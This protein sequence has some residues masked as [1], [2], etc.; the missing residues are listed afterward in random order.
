MGRFWKYRTNCPDVRPRGWLNLGPVPHWAPMHCDATRGQV[1]ALLVLALIVTLTGCGSAESSAGAGGPCLD[2]YERVIGDTGIAVTGESQSVDA[3]LGYATINYCPGNAEHGGLEADGFFYSLDSRAVDAQPGG[4][5]AL[6]A[7]G[8]PGARLT[9]A[10]PTEDP[11]T[12]APS[13][14]LTRADETTW[15]LTAPESVGVHRLEMHLDW[16]YGEATYAALITTDGSAG[17]RTT[18]SGP[19]R[20]GVSTDEAPLDDA[21]AAELIFDNGEYREIDFAGGRALSGEVRGVDALVFVC[22]GIQVTASDPTSP[23]LAQLM[24][25]VAD[26]VLAWQECIPTPP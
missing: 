7:P 19:P 5:I 21:I 10:W 17:T 26:E 15:Q 1:F 6:S 24:E 11:A 22:S 14:D 20:P 13:A 25:D 8:Y 9:A 3:S 16:A 12:S 18:T 23:G 4:Q 2:E